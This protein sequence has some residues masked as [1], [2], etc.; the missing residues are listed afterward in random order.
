[1][2]TRGTEFIGTELLKQVEANYDYRIAELE[3]ELNQL[4]TLTFQERHQVWRA[5][6]ERMVAEL[7]LATLSGTATDSQL[8]HFSISSPPYEGDN[9]YK[10]ESRERQIDDLRRAKGKALAYIKSLAAEQGVVTLS[11]A[12]LRRIGYQP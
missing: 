8:S 11:A 10:I 9:D 7:Y 5:T 4:N 2:A 12:D 3:E 1:M 6:A